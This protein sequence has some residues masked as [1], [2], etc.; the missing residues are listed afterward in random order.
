MA[1]PDDG[2]DLCPVTPTPWGPLLSEVGGDAGGGQ[3]RL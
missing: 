1:S 3:G 2:D